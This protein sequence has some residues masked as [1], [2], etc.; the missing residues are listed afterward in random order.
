MSSMPPP[1]Q[2]PAA[3]EDRP[4]RSSSSPSPA[5]RPRYLVV[6]LVGAL[7]FGAGCWTE[8]CSR[9]AFYRGEQNHAD[10]IH[11]N[12]RDPQDRSRAEDL[13]QRFVDTA[14]AQRG[15]AVPIAAATFVL[16]AAL[17]ALAARGLGGRSNTRSALV[18]VVA[19]QAI[20]VAGAYYATRATQSAEDDWRFE[21]VMLEQREKVPAAQ[22]DTQIVPTLRTARRIGPP[23]WLAMRSLASLL[24]VFALT[25]R[26]SIEFFESAAPG[27]ISES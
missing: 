26:R 15:R 18:Q 3:D 2:E 20:V 12:I 6:A 9:L 17:L 19:A 10:I 14:N 21:C 5:K 8:G 4:L 16:G 1:S 24:I 13:Y 27:P 23:L 22:Y 7:V 11:A 25:R